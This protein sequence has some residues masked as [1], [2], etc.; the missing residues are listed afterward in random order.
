MPK[1]VTQRCLEQ[2]FNPRPTDRKPKCL[3]VA[4]PRHL[5]QITYKYACVCCVVAE[6][7]LKGSIATEADSQLSWSG[8]GA[9]R[10]H[11]TV[12]RF[13]SDEEDDLADDDDEVTH[14]IV[15]SPVWAPGP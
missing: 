5:C 15:H 2:D 12:V 14:H 9:E 6:N 1:I 13:A 8:G 4:P 10:V 7:L 11:P 3:T